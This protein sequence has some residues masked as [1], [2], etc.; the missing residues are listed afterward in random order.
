MRWQRAF[1]VHLGIFTIVTTIYPRSFDVLLRSMLDYPS[2]ASLASGHCHW[3]RRSTS[4]CAFRACNKIISNLSHSFESLHILSL[5]QY[6]YEMIL[7]GLKMQIAY[8]GLI[9]RKVSKA[10]EKANVP[11]QYPHV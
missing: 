6:C 9:Y 1:V 11:K 10:K 3:L 8:S 7:C 5:L 2:L 4:K